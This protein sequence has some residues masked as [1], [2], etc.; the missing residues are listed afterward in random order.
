MMNL[1]EF[2]QGDYG[3]EDEFEDLEVYNSEDDTEADDSIRLT[4]KAGEKQMKEVLSQ[5]TD[6]INNDVAVLKDDQKLSVITE[7][8]NENSSINPNSQTSMIEMKKSRMKDMCMSQLGE[9]KFNE[10]HKYLL[11]HRKKG[12]DDQTVSFSH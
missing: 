5:Y 12:T 8:S 7:Q 9:K 10:I 1:N 2:G 3:V 4:Q 11:H 6:F